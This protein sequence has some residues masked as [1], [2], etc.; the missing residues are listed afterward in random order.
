MQV[1]FNELAERELTTP[2]STTNTKNRDWEPPSLPKFAAVPTRSPK[3]LRLAPSF[4]APFAG[5]CPSVSLTRFSTRPAARN[6]EFL[7]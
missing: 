3:I 5:A 6:F 2:H 1:T 4:L 7:L